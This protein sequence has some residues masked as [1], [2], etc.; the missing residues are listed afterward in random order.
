M[1][2]GEQ[3]ALPGLETPRPGAGDLEKATH[4]TIA[5]LDALGLIE[6]RH[7]MT[8]QLMIELAR[9]VEAG[10]KS[11]RASAVALAAAQ[12]RE[13]FMS[14]PEPETTPDG[15]DAWNQ[16]A[17]DLRAAAAAA[18]AEAAADG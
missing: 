13:A 14:L 16:L 4:R 17:D 7:A 10:R 12:L 8:C 18:V 11:G 15:D 2:A 5:E 3:D 1:S 9:A 6:P